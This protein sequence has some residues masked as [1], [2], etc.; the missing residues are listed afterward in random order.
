MQ[1]DEG[2]DVCTSTIP[3][4]SSTVGGT[5]HLDQ[6]QRPNHLTHLSLFGRSMAAAF[7]FM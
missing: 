7:L 5:S 4:D 3:A 1:A 2:E 6:V